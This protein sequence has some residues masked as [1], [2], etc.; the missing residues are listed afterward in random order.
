MKIGNCINTGIGSVPF[1]DIKK[2]VD[3]ITRGFEMP[4]WPQFPKIS[5]KE[6]MY[7]QYSE[8][9]P[10]IKYEQDKIFFERG[11]NFDKSAEEFMERYISDNL[12]SFKLS[13]EYAKG[14]HELLS[15]DIKK[16]FVKGQIT[17]PIS[18]GLQICDKNK[19]PVLYD[20]IMMDIAVKNITMK[21][22]Y[23]VRELKKI[24]DNVVMFIDEPFMS[25]FGSALISISREQIISYLNEI[26]GNLNCI[27]G[28]H[29]CSNTDWSLI[30]DMN[31]DILSFD[32]YSYFDKFLIYSNEIKKFIENGKTIAWGIVPTNK[33]EIAV[34]DIDSIFN[35]LIEQINQLTKKANI[36]VSQILKQSIITPSCGT[37]S[38]DENDAEKVFNFS[39]T[40]SLKLKEE[41]GL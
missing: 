24:A 18:F 19:K 22:K 41:F 33:E 6:N 11:D 12:D 13:E 10:G 5:Q 25:A 31:L 34:N 35:L 14:F 21:A 36:E 39:K 16:D 3:F 1:S 17:G 20:D 30:L 29:C 26:L 40:I 15:R 27:K 37:G 9:F 2:A 4:F 8:N 38:L 28:V 7:V 23:Q 32:A